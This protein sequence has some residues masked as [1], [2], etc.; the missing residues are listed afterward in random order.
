MP[1][2]SNKSTRD[3]DLGDILSITDG[4]LVSPRHIEGI[5]DILNFMTG[6]NLMTHQLPR[7]M[8]ECQEPL[9][10]QHPRLR[11]VGLPEGV[12]HTKDA[13]YAWLDS[14]KVVY[15][16]TLPVMPLADGEHEFRNPIAEADQMMGNRPVIV[17]HPEDFRE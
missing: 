3:F 8:R 9:L 5:Y 6:D 12:E 7:A 17:V 16:D 11:G 10:A 1:E 4:A 2:T 15:G 13:V 14:A